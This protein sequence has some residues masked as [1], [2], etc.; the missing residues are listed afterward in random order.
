MKITVCRDVFGVLDKCTLMR[1]G[2]L[3][4]VAAHGG[5]TELRNRKNGELHIQ[6]SVK[7]DSKQTQQQHHHKQQKSTLREL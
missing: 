5:S 7:N 1:G 3:R 4:E 2:R 6:F